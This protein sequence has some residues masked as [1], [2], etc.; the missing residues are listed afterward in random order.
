MDHRLQ[1]FNLGAMENSTFKLDLKGKYL[2]IA[3]D[4]YFHGSL[5]PQGADSP[6]SFRKRIFDGMNDLPDGN[7]AIFCHS[8]ILKIFLKSIKYPI[9]Y[10][11]NLGMILVEFD[12]IDEEVEIKGIFHGYEH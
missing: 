3:Y 8:G 4:C 11:G 2:T 6:Y 1:E 12:D 9:Q 7:S 10:F 5:I